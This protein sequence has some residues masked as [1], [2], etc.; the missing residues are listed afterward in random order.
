MFVIRR[1]NAIAVPALRSSALRSSALR[2]LLSAFRLRAQS[3]KRLLLAARSR[4]STQTFLHLSLCLFPP[5]PR[6]P[7]RAGAPAQAGRADRR[8]PGR[9]G[10]PGTPSRRAAPAAARPRAY[11]LPL[12]AGAEPV[13][14]ER[15]GCLGASRGGPGAEVARSGAGNSHRGPR[16]RSSSVDIMAVALRSACMHAGA[17]AP[18]GPTAAQLLQSVRTRASIEPLTTSSIAGRSYVDVILYAADSRSYG[19]A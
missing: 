15:G 11:P 4:L 17:R 16:V 5:R 18:A 13:E 3:K 1:G 12:H 8:V 10:A 19:Q 2:F 9:A 14:A 7:P 6:R